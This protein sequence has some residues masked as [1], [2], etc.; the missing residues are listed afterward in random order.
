M[1]EINGD[2]ALEVVELALGAGVANRVDCESDM[3]AIRVD[4]P[5]RAFSARRGR[6]CGEREDRQ[7]NP[8]HP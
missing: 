2:A 7:D 6:R 1:L 8:S 4:D 5:R 3:G